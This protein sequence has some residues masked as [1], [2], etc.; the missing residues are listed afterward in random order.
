MTILQHTPGPWVIAHTFDGAIYPQHTNPQAVPDG[1]AIHQPA[2]AVA[3][4]PADGALCAAAPDLLEACE[5]LLRTWGAIARTAG[6]HEARQ[7][8]LKA[9]AAIAKAKGKEI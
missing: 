7:A 8:G 2:I 1:A 4:K 3:Y 6:S 5:E 9:E